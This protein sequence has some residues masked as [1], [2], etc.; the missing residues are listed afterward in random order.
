MELDFQGF[1]NGDFGVV[2]FHEDVKINEG[3]RMRKPVVDELYKIEKLVNRIYGETPKNVNNNQVDFIFKDFV[4]LF[5]T[6]NICFKLFFN[7]NKDN[8][9]TPA[10]KEKQLFYNLNSALEPHEIV[11]LTPYRFVKDKDSTDCFFIVIELETDVG[12]KITGKGTKYLKRLE[13]IVNAMYPK[14]LNDVSNANININSV[15]EDVITL[16]KKGVFHKDI[17]KENIMITENNDI[18]LI[19]FGSCVVDDGSDIKNKITFTSAVH[20]LVYMYIKNGDILPEQRTTSM[21]RI[22]STIP[23]SIYNNVFN[24]NETSFLAR[25]MF[26]KKECFDLAQTFV[27]MGITKMIGGGLFSCFRPTG[28]KDEEQDETIEQ[29]RKRFDNTVGKEVAR[30][31]YFDINDYNEFVLDYTIHKVKQTQS[32]GKYKK[33]KSHIRMKNAKKLYKVRVDKNGKKYIKMN[34]TDVYLTNIKNKYVYA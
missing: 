6:K 14:N 27:K 5:K 34:K 33:S 23:C 11:N 31:I 7:T 18:K 25:Y 10:D 32:G 12:V 9:V 15:I 24:V 26:Y 20:P 1:P 2:L 29:Y 17:K 13:F 8:E 21:S 3:R 19:D 28:V 16:C 22:V 30:L 4:E